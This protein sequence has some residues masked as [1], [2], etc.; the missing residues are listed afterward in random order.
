VVGQGAVQARGNFEFLKNLGTQWKR[1]HIK[2]TLSFQPDR[3]DKKSIAADILVLP[4]IQE[5]LAEIAKV[6]VGGEGWV[7]W[8]SV[9]VLAPVRSVG[10]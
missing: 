5:S 1:I 9:E 2:Y 7:I 8:D 3:D 6:L 4:I 10:F